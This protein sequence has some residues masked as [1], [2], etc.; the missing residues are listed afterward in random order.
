MVIYFYKTN[1]E[2]GCFS[3]FAHFP[4]CLDGKMWM[5][6]EHYFQAQKFYNTIYEEKI[7]LLDNPMKA[8]KMGRNINLPLRKT[9]LI[10]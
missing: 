3:N 10:R 1:D 5:T 2:Y 8:A 6:S 9:R 7:R 4:F